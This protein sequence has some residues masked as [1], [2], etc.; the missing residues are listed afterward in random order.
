MTTFILYLIFGYAIP[1]SD[2]NGLFAPLIFTF[3]LAY[4]VAVMFTEI[5]GMC[6]ETILI[7]FIADEE[8]FAPEQRFADGGLKTTMQ[9]TAQANA[10]KVAPATEVKEGEELM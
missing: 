6:I 7:C 8:M 3:L 5:F 2:I 9:K 4:F 10:V 1:S